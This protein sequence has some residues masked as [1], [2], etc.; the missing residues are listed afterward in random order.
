MSFPTSSPVDQ[1]GE[2]LSDGRPV[3][4]QPFGDSHDARGERR[5]MRRPAQPSVDPSLLEHSSNK[6][7]DSLRF[8]GT[9]LV[10]FITRFDADN[11][12]VQVFVNPR[13]IVALQAMEQAE[14]GGTWI[15]LRNRETIPVVHWE[16]EVQYVLDVVCGIPIY[17]YNGNDAAMR[18]V[19]GAYRREVLG[20]GQGNTARNGLE[21]TGSEHDEHPSDQELR[22]QREPNDGPAT[23]PDADPEYREDAMSS[24][25]GSSSESEPSDDSA[26]SVP[27]HLRGSRAEREKRKAEAREKVLAQRPS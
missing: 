20:W 7:S 2:T 5:P 6:L 15:M 21:R 19:V 18:R 10:Q 3:N 17:R 8:S 9:G 26:L 25:E 4:P 12:P 22:D 24:G 23:A 14:G 13:E 16:S 11:K 27:S 1:N